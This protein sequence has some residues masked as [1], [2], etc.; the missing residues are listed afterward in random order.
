MKI[1]KKSFLNSIIVATFLCL[2]GKVQAKS[3]GGEVSTTSGISFFEEVSVPVIDTVKKS[4]ISRLPQTGEALHGYIWAGIV[5]V[6]LS[7]FAFY[8]MKRRQTRE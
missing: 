3:M 8:L 2:T 5:L 6:A 4:I 1:V 7:L